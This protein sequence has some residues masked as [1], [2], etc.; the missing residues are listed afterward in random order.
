MPGRFLK[1]LNIRS[2][3]LLLC[4]AVA[5]PL[6]VIG[7]LIIWSEYK[8]LKAEARRATTFQ[9]A[10]AVR[11]LSRWLDSQ[12]QGL[13][14]LASLPALSQLDL[15]AASRILTT[16]SRAQ[17]DRQ[18]IA[19]FDRSGRVLVASAG[20]ENRPG[21]T[22][23]LKAYLKQLLA[24]GKTTVSGYLHCPVTGRPA[25][26]FG[27]PVFQ[28]GKPRALLIASESPRAVLELFEGLDD[29][30]GS[31]VTVVDAHHRVL[32]RTL[33]NE[34]WLGQDFSRAR[35]VQAAGRAWKGT[36]EGVGIADPTARAY[37]FDRV[38]KANWLVIVG[39]PTASI[40][41]AAQNWL[42]MVALLAGCAV[43]LS[44]LLAYAAT[45]HFTRPINELVREALAIGRG[46]LS[47]RVRVPSG[48]ELGLLARAFNQM[49]SNLEIN[50]EHKL[51]VEKISE[52]IRQSLDLNEILN[53]TVTELGQELAASRCCLALIDARSHEDLADDH[54]V[55]DYVWSDQAKA[56]TA[57]E[58][59]SIRITSDSL[60]KLILQ[61]D[62]VLSMDVLDDSHFAALFENHTAK[63]DGWGSIKSLIACPISTH[64]R[65]LGLIVVQQCDARRTWLDP[66][67]ELVE[68]V[69]RHVALAME[70]ARLFAQTKTLADQELLINHIVGSLRSSLDLDTIL[71]TVTGE[72]G[73]ALSSD[74]C[75]IAL[76][77]SEGPLVVTHEFHVEMLQSARG[78]SVYSDNL[79]FDPLSK[80]EPDSRSVLGVNLS[81]LGSDS[82]T[83]GDTTLE[84]VPLAVMSDVNTDSQALAF[85]EFLDSV[86][87]KSLITAPLIGD[88]RLLGLLMVH[89][90]RQTHQWTSAEVSLV[91]AIADQVAI[92]ISHAQ[93][94]AQVKHQ[95][96]TD[97]LTGLYN[98]VYLKNRL[99]EEIRMAQR[100]SKPCSLLM[101]DLDKLKYINDSFG[102]PV[103][104][105]A[106]RHVAW[107][108][109]NLLRSGDTAA[110]YG[111][112]EFAVILPET[113][114]AEAAL[115]GDRL[116]R[117][118]NNSP[119]PGLGRVSVSIG[120][121]TFPDQSS[122]LKG[123]IDKA[124]KALYE[125]KQAG[126][127]QVRIW[128]Q[129]RSP[130][131]ASKGSRL[132][133]LD[134]WDSDAQGSP[135]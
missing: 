82:D 21:Q 9:A 87:T 25:L 66:E 76:P 18:A 97:G 56:G 62:A 38:P 104:D 103:G 119:V 58:S 57:L 110:R 52:S 126:R 4:L 128:N 15:D 48:D 78:L 37:A 17:H 91:A 123:L 132:T 41:G 101:I 120:A 30:G 100:K 130:V 33:Q 125:A 83:T 16:A 116:C 95:A 68:D 94:F 23:G 65:P 85:R 26:L 40:Y 42:S 6:L 75:Q 55:F 45:G 34:R 51:M 112:E 117:Q 92:A 63:P 73:R 31:V 3:L 121:A 35:T 13:E 133:E 86:G 102:H 105:S 106:I 60:L 98:H 72:L 80:L 131:R 107:T 108:L 99:A 10:I 81:N 47:K 134:A 44:L 32:A 5:T 1:R 2:R 129:H 69:A 88:N 71:N 67:L 113:P 19:L 14:A 24:S 11:A 12:E 36:L 64:D 43:S 118:V 70:H 114:L 29:A 7:G 127:N 39:V 54:L 96:I 22:A 49:S 74:R 124:D 8:N 109:K 59:R 28:D 79:S 89:H 20:I 135:A 90:C 46:D 77:R 93:L 27:T 122:D 84:N 61:Q 115:I 50:Q 53:T 111:G